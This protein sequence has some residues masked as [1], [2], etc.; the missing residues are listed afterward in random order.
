[1][2]DSELLTD[3]CFGTKVFKR[4]KTND[5]IKSVSQPEATEFLL[6]TGHEYI[7]QTGPFGTILSCGLINI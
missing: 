3:V 1:M 6:E 7:Y 4:F 5:V 2:V